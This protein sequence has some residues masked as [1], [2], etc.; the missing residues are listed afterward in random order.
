MRRGLA[1]PGATDEA[2]LGARLVA[3]IQERPL[4]AM[5]AAGAVGAMLGGVLFGRV[6]RLVFVGA[7]GYLANELWRNEGRLDLLRKIAGR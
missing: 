1:I 2:V 3:L 4:V 7:L 5:V 6:G